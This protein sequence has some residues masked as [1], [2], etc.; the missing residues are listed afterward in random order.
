MATISTH[1]EWQVDSKGYRF[2]RS[3]KPKGSLLGRREHDAIVRRGGGLQTRHPLEHFDT[4][5][6]QFS[7][8]DDSVEAYIDFASK[9]GPLTENGHAPEGDPVEDWR[10][11]VSY[12]K[13]LI[14]VREV[15][16]QKLIYDAPSPTEFGRMRARLVAQ[17]PGGRP[18]L[19]LIPVSL[20]DAL[21]LQFAQSTV[22]G[23]D[24]RTCDWC[25]TW[26]ESGGGAGR[27]AGA[28][29]CSEK[30]R[31]TFNNRKKSKGVRS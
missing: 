25:G 14:V 2:E 10:F 30:C 17:G 3:H 19:R 4:L 29:F 27:R 6:K 24:L 28:R 22:S 31:S 18:A 9:F 15:D 8:L 1:F 7:E 5:Y 12:M 11:W 16:P 21:W 26:F 23:A 20:R 13:H